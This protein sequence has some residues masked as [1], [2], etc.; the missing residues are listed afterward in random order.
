MYE[1]IIENEELVL[2]MNNLRFKFN[3]L[4]R[5]NNIYNSLKYIITCAST[6]NSISTV[7][8]IDLGFYHNCTYSLIVYNDA[9]HEINANLV[10]KDIVDSRTE[11]IELVDFTLDDLLDIVI[12]MADYIMLL[13]NQII[14]VK[15]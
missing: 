2:N 7:S 15:E 14:E 11:S 12:I 13:N 3:D 8:T 10:S 6:E 9:Y 1:A 5:V 4:F